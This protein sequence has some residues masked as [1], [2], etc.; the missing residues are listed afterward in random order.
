MIN[1]LP[2]SIA[3]SGSGWI[4]GTPVVV[5]AVSDF[6]DNVDSYLGE[7]VTAASAEMTD[8]LRAA[9]LEYPDWAPYAD[10][11][12]VEWDVDGFGFFFNG[13]EDDIKTMKA[14]EYGRDRGTAPKSVTR[15]VA[16]RM[17][18]RAGKLV[19]QILERELGLA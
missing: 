13:T 17:E 5:N 14:L 19:Q 1:A 12:S 4:S 8:A 11:L 9:A 10:Q 7:A 3:P 15:K 2:Q 6:I 18:D 16:I